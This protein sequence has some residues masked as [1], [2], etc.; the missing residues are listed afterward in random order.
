ME[1]KTDP[2]PTLPKGEGSNQISVLVVLT[3]IGLLLYLPLWLGT[4][5]ISHVQHARGIDP[6]LP[7]LPSDSYGY[8]VLAD[9]LAE[10]H[11]FSASPTCAV[12]ETFR[13]PGYPAFLAAFDTFG[14]PFVASFVQCLLALLTGY[15]LY[16]I[17][18]VYL[19]ERWSLW[20]M[21]IFLLEPSVILYSLTFLSDILFTFLIVVSAYFL[22][23]AKPSF[24]MLCS[25]GALL[26]L[27][28]LVRPISL[29]LL[30]V[31]AIFYFLLYFPFQKLS[32]KSFCKSVTVLCIGFAVLILPWM[33]RNKVETGTFIFSTVSGYNLFVYN[34]PMF[35][36]AETGQSVSSIQAQ[37]YKDAGLTGQDISQAQYQS[38][39]MSVSEKIIFAHPFSYAAFH[40]VKT[41]PFYI[42]S[43]VENTQ[44]VIG[45]MLPGASSPE[46]PALTSY[47]LS[48]DVKGL[49]RALSAQG[50]IVFE[51]MLWLIVTLLALAS[52]CIVF[53]YQ[54]SNYRKEYVVRTLFLVVM[55]LYFGILTG[56]VSSPRYRLPAE[57]FM[58]LAAAL[59]ISLGISLAIDI[60]IRKKQSV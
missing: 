37:M 44:L 46:R 9:N 42:S 29:F 32:I 60:C 30:P 17:S 52:V 7:T 13:T 2:T 19:S 34:V 4:I 38:K 21:I 28:A 18:R 16:K 39:V 53:W 1:T 14:S 55:M 3:V 25:I 57:P 51:N 20:I 15:F 40:L 27:S 45:E 49:S 36:S 31:Y 48:H 11:C 47:I 23:K 58:F 8:K 54:K 10:H 41:I 12:S 56:P 35:V 24:W 43:S 50:P 26:A 22:L 33:I 59:C 5:Y 6:V